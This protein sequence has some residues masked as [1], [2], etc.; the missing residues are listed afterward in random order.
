MPP[1]ILIAL[2]L[3]LLGALYS[4]ISTIRTTSSR[5]NS[6]KND[7]KLPPGPRALPIIGNLHMLGKLP[8]RKLSHLAKK[9][10]PIMSIRLGY[11]P[12]IVV[13]SPQV[14]ELFLKTHDVIFASRPKIQAS[15]YIS[16]GA[17]GIAFT[18]YGSYWR[19][20]R[21]WC[22][23]HLLSASKVE[24][25][26]PIRKAE[27]RSLVESLKKAAEA[28]ETVDLSEKIAEVVENIAYKMI[29]G[30]RK[31]DSLDMKPTI[32]EVINLTGVF[33]L[34]DYVPILASFDLQGLVRR[35]KTLSKDIDKY[36]EKIIDEHEQAGTTSREEQNH[37][38]DFVDVMISML[39]QP[40][41]P[42]D[43]EQEHYIIDR[44]NIKA[45]LLDM[46]L[47]AFETSA[48]VVEW[49]LSELL[50]HPRAMLGF[51]KELETVVGRN[52][53]V[54]ES[55]LPEF[56]YLDMILKESLR[57]HPVAPFLLPHESMEDIIIDG[58]YFIPKKSRI[59]VNVWA[60]GRDPN[61]WS[62]NVEEFFPERFIGS[63]I[64]LRGH[65]FQLIPFGSGRRGC[66]GMQLGLVMVRFLLAQLVHCF[67]WDLPN[68]MLPDELDMSENFGLSLP[69]AN[70]LFA[71]PTYRLLD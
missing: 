16:Y 18:E 41:N 26:A 65:D 6:P 57:L 71:K 20:V 40:M 63:K 4:F 1:S 28:G 43:E 33:N 48:T 54:E 32:K 2:L 68:D 30:P 12:T 66:P 3:V 19:T 11:V 55:D 31:D 38:R 34:S 52:R 49:A 17:K 36:L 13:S 56:T 39:N 70:H 37:H 25:F 61:I 9:Y 8:H 59:L 42:Y 10:G 58:R 14:A 5:P 47:G 7:R 50:S 60:M 35:F 46:I 44:T 69:R 21:K 45:I 67:D 62:D 24:H 51:R 15:K 53:M 64:E 22:T 23:L 27:L 29:F